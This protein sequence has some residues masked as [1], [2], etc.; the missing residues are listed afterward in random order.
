MKH[1]GTKKCLS[2]EATSKN[3]TRLEVRSKN[4]AY[5]MLMQACY[6]RVII[7]FFFLLPPRSESNSI[8]WATYMV[9]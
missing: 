6:L 3:S 8:A 2:L 4:S 1:I 9:I 5:V 7:I